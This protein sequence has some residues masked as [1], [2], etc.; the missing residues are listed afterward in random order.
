VGTNAD[1]DPN[2]EWAC[3]DISVSSVFSQ[4]SKLTF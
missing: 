4:S 1:S 2:G 3:F